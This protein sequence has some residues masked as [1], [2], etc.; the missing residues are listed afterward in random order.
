MFKTIVVGVDGREGGR[1][2]L[3]LAGRLALLAGG[4]VIAV[5]V[6]PFDYYVSR[7]GAPPYASIAEQDA[8]RELEDELAKAGLTARIRVL[9]DSSPARALHRVAEEERA[10]VIAV[11]S[12]HHGRIGR[13]FAG[14]D[15]AATLHGSSCP[16]AVAPR[17]LAAQEW[18]AVHTIGVGFDGGPEA[19]Q[20]AAL[21]VALASECGASIRVQ[22][23]VG[24]P[25][26]YA[27][28]S[29]YDGDWVE[30]AQQA[31]SDDVGELLADMDIEAAGNT[32]VGV[33]V[34]ELTKL[35]E[36]VDLLV[37]GSRAWGPV[38]RIVVGSTAA[39]LI[40]K[41]HCPVLVLPR[42]A[43]TGQPGEAEPH[44]AERE[45]PATA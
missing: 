17:G 16:V 37:V 38:R 18:K 43:A 29:G 27:D 33:T 2:A 4:D 34:D 11:G 13:V 32:V 39:S 10:D 44:T 12:T 42:G 45:T 22:W 41:A 24:T 3:S 36:E 1:D 25:I 40:R 8:K 20:A 35:S 9:G 15:A 30:R 7:G 19:R 23:V 5:R 6:L 26:P 21:A 14:D 28:M 31:A